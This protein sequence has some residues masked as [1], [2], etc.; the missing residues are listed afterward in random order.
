MIREVHVY[1]PPLNPGDDSRGEAQHT[2][3]G[4]ALIDRARAIARAA[5]YS[6]LAVI[7]AVGT[8]AYYG[9]LGFAPDGLY[10]S[11][12]LDDPAASEP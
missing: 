3:L 5:G 8:R 12:A 9:R 7:S 4:A 1:G 2:G 6:Q 10:M 11:T